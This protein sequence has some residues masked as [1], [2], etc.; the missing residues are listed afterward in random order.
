MGVTRPIELDV[1]V[2]EEISDPWGLRRVGFAATGSI[3]RRDFG[4]NWGTPEPN[5]VAGF[6]VGIRIDAEATQA[7]G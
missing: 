4:M 2:S 7:A 5:A 3:D 6:E 1:Q